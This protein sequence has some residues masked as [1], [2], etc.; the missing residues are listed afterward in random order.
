MQQHL[1]PLHGDWLVPHLSH[2]P[3]QQV[4]RLIPTHI[5]HLKSVAPV[6]MRAAVLAKK[7][8]KDKRRRAEEAGVYVAED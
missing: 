3:E 4:Q 7:E 2:L 1:T 5:K 6:N 8:A